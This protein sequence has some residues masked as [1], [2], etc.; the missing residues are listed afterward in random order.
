M[1]TIK[2][3]GICLLCMILFLNMQGC[4]FIYDFDYPYE[5]AAEEKGETL[6][7]ALKE[8]DA[9]VIKGLFSKYARKKIKNF[10]EKIEDML[11]FMKG[12]IISSKV[13]ITGGSASKGEQMYTDITL[14]IE[15]KTTQDKYEIG[16]AD[17]AKAEKSSREGIYYLDIIGNK[18]DDT[19]TWCASR[20]G[21]PGI[22]FFFRDAQKV[23]TGKQ[24]EEKGEI[25]A[26]ALKERDA[27]AIKG[28]FSEY[29]KTN[30][31]DFDTKVERWI[32]FMKGN[33]TST[34]VYI[35]FGYSYNGNKESYTRNLICIKVKTDQGKYILTA[36]DCVGEEQRDKLGILYL[37]MINEKDIEE[38]EEWYIYWDRPNIRYLSDAP[39]D[40]GPCD[41]GPSNYDW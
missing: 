29:A 35:S 17:R 37:D 14:Y 22:M 1:K 24:T 18:V 40:D 9:D 28:V 15:V 7:K 13:E 32:D 30:I 36:T 8:K 23:E 34:K 4:M 19:Y 21:V 6:V 41:E 27:D 33:V 31:K 20:G 12:D 11:G 38:V 2:R 3:V 5:V 39:C 25:I 16:I 26:K 10:D